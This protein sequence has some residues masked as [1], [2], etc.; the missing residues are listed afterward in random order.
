MDI[1]HFSFRIQPFSKCELCHT[2]CSVYNVYIFFKEQ[3]PFLSHDSENRGKEDHCEPE[4][5]PFTQCQCP[6]WGRCLGK[7]ILLKGPFAFQ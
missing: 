6:A 7:A 2:Q 1:S 4:G 5:Q 3:Y